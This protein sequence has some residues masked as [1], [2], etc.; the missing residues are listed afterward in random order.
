MS[1]VDRLFHMKLFEPHRN[2][3]EYEIEN[4]DRS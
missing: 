3:D 2:G 4:R 1:K